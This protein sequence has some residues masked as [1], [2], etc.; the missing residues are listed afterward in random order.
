MQVSEYGSLKEKIAAESKAR[1]AKYAAFEAAYAKA[2]AAGQAAGEAAKPRAMMVVQPSN[3]L[4]DNSVP[5]AMWHVPEGVCGFAWVK[6][7]PGNSPF[8]NWLK[9][10]KLARKAY[11]SGVDIWISAFGQSMERKEACAYAMAKV[12]NEEL[13]SNS[14]QIYAS[15]RMD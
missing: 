11:G 5:K 10:N 1:K 7:S 15:S 12:L 9:K 13:A 2:A 14:L 8:A 6:V 3:P 4:N